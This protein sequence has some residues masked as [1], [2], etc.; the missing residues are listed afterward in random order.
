MKTSIE[1]DGKKLVLNPFIENL[2][3]NILVS[4]AKS[5]KSPEGKRIIFILREE[6]LS[7]SVDEITVPLNQG[8]AQRIVGH[9]LRGLFKSLHGAE[10]GKSFQFV[11]ADERRKRRA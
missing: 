2:T 5:L 6:E 11:I 9:V 7:M 8:S 1:V 10:T 3:C 4:I